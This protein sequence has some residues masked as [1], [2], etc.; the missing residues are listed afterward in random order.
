MNEKAV[1]DFLYPKILNSYGVAALMG[2][3]YVESKLNPRNLQGSYER[4]LNMTDEQYTY[5]VDNG[6]YPGFVDDRAGYGLAQWTYPT[7]KENLLNYALDHGKSIGDLNMQLEFLWQELQGY[8]TCLNALKAATSVREA[9]DVVVDRYEKPADRSE[10]GKQNRA[11]YGQQFYDKFAAKKKCKQIV[12]TTDR[13]NIRAGNNTEYKKIG[14]CNK[15]DLFDWI[16]TAENGWHAIRYVDQV[17]W[18]SGD[19]SKMKE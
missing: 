4:K 12:I 6:L 9:S 16:A 13:V 1:W 2:N 8:T 11:N 5:S 19:F 17:A 7:R 14:V 10:K 18:V 15:N 3:L